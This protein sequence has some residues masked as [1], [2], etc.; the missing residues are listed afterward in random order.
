MEK[1]SERYLTDDAMRRHPALYAI[2]SVLLPFL[3]AVLG[4]IA[5]HIVPFGDK[6]SLA[7]VDGKY[8][9]NN[10]AFLKRQL[11]GQ[12]NFLYSLKNGL[13]GNE[14]SLLAWGGFN[15]VL[16]LALFTNLETLPTWFTWISI[17]NMAVCGLTMYI[18]LAGVYG[19][20]ASHLIFST[21]YALM[22]FNVVNCYQTLFFIGPQM[23]PLVILSIVWLFRERSPLPYI[24]SLMTCI[25]FNFYFGFI[26]CVASTV[27]FFAA[28]YVRE[29]LKGRRARL[30]ARWIVS[31]IIAG[32]LAAPMWLPALKAYSGGGRLNQTILPHYSFVENAPFIQIFSKLFSGANSTSEVVNGLPN[33][34]CGILTV[35]LVILFFMDRQKSKRKKIAVGVT[36]GFYLVTFYLPALTNVMHG[37]TVTN[38]FPYR[39]SFV[40]SF[41]LLWIAAEEFETVEALT[42]DD[43]KRCGAILL[44][45]TILVFA[46]KYEFIAGGAVV[47][48]LALL[49]LMALGFWLYKT[50][51]EQTPRRVLVM[52]L[53]LVVSGNLYANCALSIKGME[54]WELDLE[55]YR[56]NIMANG[57]L[58]DALNK[59]ETDFFR[60]EKEESDS[61]SVGADPYLYGYNGVSHSGPGERWFVHIVLCQLGLNWFDMRHW[62]TEGVPAATDALLGLKYI[63]SD[64]DLTEKK[65][66]EKRATIGDKSIFQ[67]A[68]YLSPA[69]VIDDGASVL[70][71]SDN[72]F[73]NLNDVWKSMTGGEE[74]VFTLQPE[75]TYRLQSSYVDQSVTSAELRESVAKAEDNADEDDEKEAEP[76]TYIEY[77]LAAPGDGALYYFDTSIPYSSNGI[78]DPTIHF[79]GVYSAG[80]TVTGKIPLQANLGT[81]DFLRGYCANLVFATENLD[82]LGEYT[83]LLNSRDITFNVDRDNHL[84]GTFTAD[85]SQRILFTV[86]WDEGWTCRIDG[87]TVPIEK[88]WNLFMSVEVPEG[89]HTYDMKFFPAWMNYGLYLSGAALL[90]LVL[91]MIMWKSRKTLLYN[92]K[93]QTLQK[94]IDLDKLMT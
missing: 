22:G 28:L 72:A 51:P 60:M 57:A 18:L 84:T 91:Y 47:L 74:D 39:Y 4:C 20:K 14:W 78:P 90:A 12:E 29:D 56:D 92:D 7:T 50:K 32:L 87:Q 55:E 37:F 35:A 43:L 16:L 45:S 70:W 49:G 67:N 75:V 46:T 85:S 59:A 5:L 27:F 38:W 83:H 48:D 41:W 86:P 17:V 34:F 80:E 25:F 40:F 13:G 76:T 79:C 88:T 53:I 89:S 66:Y 54:E 10:V 62:Y 44:V 52:F 65:G 61:G 36:L 1:A 11:T 9:L 82:V 31:S 77:T 69:I 30:F 15:P 42:F 33:I 68:N 81:G 6:H 21:S 8:Y 93:P 2:L 94:R 23:L 73:E 3:I 63:I 58:V 26:L 24:L 71:P 19:H 64:N